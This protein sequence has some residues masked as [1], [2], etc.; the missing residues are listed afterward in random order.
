M[1]IFNTT[2][3][4]VETLAYYD[5][6]SNPSQQQDSA[7]DITAGDPNITFNPNEGRYQAAGEAIAYWRDWF[8]RSEKADDLE[9][10]LRGLL[11]ESGHD[12]QAE[13]IR[14]NV[15]EHYFDHAE[16]P[17]QRIQLLKRCLE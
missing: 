8:D 11:N 2:T 5:R 6:S 17:G 4:E 7:P 13:F 16:W 14:E 15:D 3:N 9:R 1:E 10:E 12:D